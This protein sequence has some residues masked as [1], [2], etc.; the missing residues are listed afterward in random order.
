MPGWLTVSLYGVACAGLIVVVAVAYGW[1]RMRTLPDT[2]NLAQQVE[3][4]AQEAL[5]EAD[6]GTV[7]VAVLRDGRVHVRRFGAQAGAAHD[8]VRF[9]IGSISKVFTTLAVHRL[10]GQA[11]WRWSDPIWPLLPPEQRPAADDGTTL[12][13]LATHTSGLPRLPERWFARMDASNDPY[14]SITS[15]DVFAAYTAGEGRTRWTEAD[16]TYSNFGFGLLGLLLE[17]RMGESYDALVQ[18]LILQPLGMQHTSITLAEGAAA[19]LVSGR[20]HTGAPTP[21]WTFDALAGAGAYRSTIEDMARFLQ[22]AVDRTPVP[23]L[24]WDSTWTPR[25]SASGASVALG[26]QLD[27]LSGRPVGI[28]RVVWHNGGTGGFSSWLGFDP[29]RR[30]GAVVLAARGGGNDAVD[31][32]GLQLLFMASHISFAP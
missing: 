12:E 13:M 10:V 21:P 25:R 24:D 18:R 32:L 7:A 1:Y 4:A 17:R 27:N 26:W 9:E 8:T 2:R 15:A 22:A 19:Q 6:L 20:D 16:D 3:Q 29:E 28:K 14:A 11:V 30:I 23:A 5:R 31:E